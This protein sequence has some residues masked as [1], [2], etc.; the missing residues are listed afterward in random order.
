MLEYFH[1]LDKEPGSGDK[2]S[3]TAIPSAYVMAGTY[4]PKYSS[5]MN[6]GMLRSSPFSENPVARGLISWQYLAPD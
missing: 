5:K 6:S 4:K 2:W 3:W 1:H